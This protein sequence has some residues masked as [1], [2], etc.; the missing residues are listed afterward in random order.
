[1]R[2]GARRNLAQILKYPENQPYAAG[3][4]ESDPLPQQ[5][6]NIDIGRFAAI[7]EARNEESAPELLNEEL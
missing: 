5:N 1:M 7:F 4:S 3:L 6:H 2:G